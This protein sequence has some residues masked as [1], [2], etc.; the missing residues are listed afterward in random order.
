MVAFHQNRLGFGGTTDFPLRYDLSV[1]GDFENMAPTDVDGTV[2]DDSA[3]TDSLSG[4]TV[5]PIRWMMSDE[6]GLL[7]GTFE[8]EWVSRPSDTSTLL[9]PSNVK[10]ARSTGY[11]SGAVEPGVTENSRISLYIRG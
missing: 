2:L 7:L 11:G 8:A 3:V 10:S 4:D 6:K 5:D 9:T 1:S